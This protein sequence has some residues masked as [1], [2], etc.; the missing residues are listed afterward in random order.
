MIYAIAFFKDNYFIT[1]LV[2]V[3]LYLSFILIILSS[4]SWW[5]DW[6]DSSWV[7]GIKYSI[8]LTFALLIL[9]GNY[10]MWNSWE[11]Y[12]PITDPGI[13]KLPADPLCFHSGCPNYRIL[14]RYGGPDSSVIGSWSSL[15]EYHYSL[16]GE[17]QKDSIKNSAHNKEEFSE[18]LDDAKSRGL[19]SGGYLLLGASLGVLLDIR[20]WCSKPF[21]W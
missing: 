17:W 18:T 3:V 1:L 20:Y 16:S 8:C 4:L 19:V 9:R 12:T 7:T 6:D 2:L 14:C 15:C 5:R 10:N 11:S 21:G 13:Y